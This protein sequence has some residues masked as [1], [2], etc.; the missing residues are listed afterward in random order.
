MGRAGW[1]K[2]WRTDV[3]RNRKTSARNSQ[4]IHLTLKQTQSRI[5]FRQ[6][7]R[8][9]RS[10]GREILTHLSQVNS[11]KQELRA[12]GHRTYLPSTQLQTAKHCKHLAIPVFHNYITRI[13]TDRPQKS[14][15]F[16]KTFGN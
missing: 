3:G 16:K 4:N 6:T 9:C 8:M 5:F 15:Y 1:E 2:C 14:M 13:R 11:D 7:R 10:T 12:W